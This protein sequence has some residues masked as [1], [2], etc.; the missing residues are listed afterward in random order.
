MNQKICIIS[1]SLKLGGIERALVVLTNYFFSTGYEVTFISCLSGG[2]FYKLESGLSL[3]EPAFK[4]SHN[5]LDKY[6][7]YLRLGIFLRSTIRKVKPDVI[8]TFGDRFSPLV[9]LSLYGLKFPVFIS[10]RT[11]PDYNFKFPTPQLKRW[12]YPLS[13]GF[14][15]QTQMAADYKIKQ[16]G[17]KLNV[18]VIPNALRSVKLYPYVRREK[19]ILYVGRFA[20]EKG[21]ERL[22]RAFAAIS[23]KL[24][25]NLYMVGS[26]PLL[27]SMNKLSFDLGISESVLFMG[28]VQEI[29]E[30]YAKSGIFVLPSILEGFPNSLCEAMA[31]GLPCICFKSI[32]YND[33]FTNGFDGLAVED[34]DIN[35]LSSTLMHLMQN[36]LLR[37]EIGSRAMEIRK[38]LSI[39]IIGPRITEFILNS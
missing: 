6:L 21:P 14:I 39:D 11:S 17:D 33:I 32:P 30:L 12:L 16:F 10:D 15:A 38:R 3:I 7:F 22:I 13:K 9:L 5:L 37:E 23:D 27:K 18:K 35:G 4:R 29:D 31:A 36:Q 26:G 1:P 28:K 20:W 19:I 2:K 34:G 24:G 8:V 25:W